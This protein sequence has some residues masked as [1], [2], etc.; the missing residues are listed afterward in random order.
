MCNRAAAST[1]RG[2]VGK[3][4]RAMCLRHII[5]IG[6]AEGV[7]FPPCSRQ[8]KSE[9]GLAGATAVRVYGFNCGNLM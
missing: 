1:L 3:P 5:R 8:V 2:T 9:H 7:Q 4:N 6:R